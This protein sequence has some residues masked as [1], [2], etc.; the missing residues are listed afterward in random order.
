MLIKYYSLKSLFLSLFTKL[1]ILSRATLLVFPLCLNYSASVFIMWSC[2]GAEISY[3]D[4]EGCSYCIAR[5]RYDFH[6]LNL[7]AF[8]SL[9]PSIPGYIS[10]MIPSLHCD[11]FR[12]SLFMTTTSILLTSG[13]LG[14]CFNLC[15]LRNDAR[16]SFLYL[17]HTASNHLYCNVFIKT[18]N[19]DV[20]TGNGIFSAM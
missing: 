3:D 16:Y 11:L 14:L 1:F 15:F 8:S 19:V 6:D 10:V 20:K 2:V 9:L 12:A 5:S 4:S 17:S 7:T 13:S 18:S